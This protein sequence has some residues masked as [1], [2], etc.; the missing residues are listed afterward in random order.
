MKRSFLISLICLSAMA[1]AAPS[2]RAAKQP[3]PPVTQTAAI[4]PPQHSL[5][6]MELTNSEMY[7][8]ARELYLRRDFAASAKVFL[9]ILGHDCSNRLAQY[10]LRKIAAA[11]PALAFLNK[12]L[13]Q[14]PCKVYDFTKEDFLPF[15]FY[16]E[17]DPELMLQQMILNNRR[18][19]LDIK[20]MNQK[21]DQYVVM[22][23]ELE[24]T[25]RML[26][27]SN[28]KIQANTSLASV[29]QETMAR[30]EQGKRSAQKI[31][32]EIIF[33]KNQL[34]SERLDRQKEVQDMRTNL[35]EAETHLNDPEPPQEPGTGLTVELPSA[36]KPSAG[37][38]YSDNA[39]ALLS[40]VEQAKAELKSKEE[41]LAEKDRL[42]LTLQSRFDDIQRRLKAIQNDLANKNAQI[43]TL[44]TNLQD[45]QRP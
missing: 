21:I 20:D 38:D 13:D 37:T 6:I 35:A 22:V 27:A 12:K 18:H 33:L 32:R 30:I 23:K 41:S 25:V 29:D 14:L 24:D 45:T 1:I 2:S 42:I 19:R 40:A 16:Y 4:K 43:E 28:A 15:S 34:A 31:E 3:E 10:H 17:K 44:Q 26:K 8:Y 5:N 7:R 36:P 9:K 11:D 39:K